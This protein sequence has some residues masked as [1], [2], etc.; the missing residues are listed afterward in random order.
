MSLVIFHRTTIAHARSIMQNGFED[1]DWDLGVLAKEDGEAVPVTGVWLSG[2]P[3][4]VSD[5][6]EGDAQ[7]EITLEATEEEIEPFEL[8]G[9]MWDTRFWVAQ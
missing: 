1:R 2:R 4:E 8:A 6:V 3:L 7:L 9:L 5:G